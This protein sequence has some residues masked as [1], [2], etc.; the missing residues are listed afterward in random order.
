MKNILFIVHIFHLNYTYIHIPIPGQI[1]EVEVCGKEPGN[2]RTM[3]YPNG[4]RGKFENLSSVQKVPAGG[5]FFANFLRQKRIQSAHMRY[6]V[7]WSSFKALINLTRSTVLIRSSIILEASYLWNTVL[8]K[9][10]AG[11]HH[12]Y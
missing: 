5:T 6:Q 11:I 8:Q 2:L 9:M 7:T 1:R 12:Q 3:V 4:M 10:S